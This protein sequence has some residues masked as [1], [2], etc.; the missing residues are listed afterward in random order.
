MEACER[1][2][3]ILENKCPDKVPLSIFT[4]LLPRGYFER[5]LRNRG[6]SLLTHVGPIID[7]MFPI[8]DTPNVATTQRRSN[9]GTETI[10]ETPAG[11]ISYE[12]R[13]GGT[14]IATLDWMIPATPLIK[15]VEDYSPLI[16][17]INDTE[18]KVDAKKFKLLVDDLGPDGIIHVILGLPPYVEAQYLLGLECWSYE[19][20]DHPKQFARLLEALEARNERAAQALLAVDDYRMV[21]LG[22]ISDNL[23]SR[24]YAK[25]A[26]P[27]FGKYSKIFRARGKKCGIHAHAKF[28]KRN[29]QV[30]AD[31]SVDFIESYTPPPYSDLDLPELREAVGDDAAIFINIPEV[32]FYEGYDKTKK[33]T[34]RLLKSDP[35]YNKAICF[36]EVGMALVNNQEVRN[37]FEEGFR[38]VVDA[39]DEMPY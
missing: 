22:D 18:I 26:I 15:K 38:A 1:L 24:D 16:Y 6:L 23:D 37:I 10:Y 29:K 8:C 36:S 27:F 20:H 7:D 4:E 39:I 34:K 12:Q 28:L 14:R 32:V 17:L 2:L 25:H 31:M 19:K 13:T 30:L 11:K 5:L 35:S 3:A 33:Y 9:L 21:Y